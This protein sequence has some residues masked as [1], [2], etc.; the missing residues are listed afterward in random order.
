MLPYR[1]LFLIVW[2]NSI[3]KMKKLSFSSPMYAD[4]T[5]KAQEAYLLYSY[6]VEKIKVTALSRV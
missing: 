5:R 6:R 3:K 1:F 4:L 2:V